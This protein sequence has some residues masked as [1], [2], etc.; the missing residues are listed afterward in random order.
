MSWRYFTRGE[1]PICWGLR[2]DCRQSLETLLVHCRYREANPPDWEEVRPDAWGFMMWRHIST[3]ASYNKSNPGAAW[4]ELQRINKQNKRCKEAHRGEL[5]LTIAILDREIRKVLEQLSLS[6][7]DRERLRSRFAVVTDNVEEQDRLIAESGC[8]SVS[9]WQKLEVAVSDRLPGVKEGGRSLLVRGDGI[10][11]PIANG[12]GKYIGWQ[13]RLD[14]PSNGN[15]Y[16]WLAGERKRA[17]RPTSHLSSGELP[18]ALYAPDSKILIESKNNTIGLAEGIGFKPQI[19][20]NRLGIPFI[21]ASSGNFAGSEKLLKQYLDFLG[22]NKSTRIVLFADAGA[23]NN[24]SVVHVY[25]KTIDLL[26]SWGYRVAIAW[27][28]QISKEDGDIDEIPTEKLETIDYISFKEFLS[29]ANEEIIDRQKPLVRSD[30]LKPE[31]EAKWFKGTID[32][33]I[34]EQQRILKLALQKA[35]LGSENS[36]KCSPKITGSNA[37]KLRETH[38]LSYKIDHR[39]HEPRLPDLTDLIPWKGILNLKSAKDTGKSYQV[40][41]MIETAKQE[42]KKIISITPRIA[43]GREQ[44]V[45]WEINW[46]DDNGYTYWVE[47]EEELTQE[48]HRQK[49]F[50]DE[51]KVTFIS[52]KVKKKVAKKTTNIHEAEALGVCWDSLYKLFQSS[53]YN[54]LVIVDEAEAG[55]KHLLT[56]STL[57]G[58]RSMILS[59]LED[60]IPECLGNG[61]M[62]VLADAD[63]SDLPIDYFKSFYPPTK[64]TTLVNTHKAPKP[65][66]IQ[67]YI[68]QKAKD[69]VYAKLLKLIAKGKKVLIPVD[70][71]KEARALEIKLN[72]LFPNKKILVV[73]RQYTQTKEGKEF[74][75]N[76]NSK[77]KA[78]K[79]DVLIYTPSINMGVSIDVKVFDLVV[80]FYYGVLEP[81]EIRQSLARYRIPV[82]RLIWCN[83]MGLFPDQCR[84]TNAKEIGSNIFKY[85]RDAL[86]QL[87]RYKK[88]RELKRE[89]DDDEILVALQDMRDFKKKEWLDVHI[90]TYCKIM[91]RRNYGLHNLAALLEHQLRQEGHKVKVRKDYVNNGLSVSIGEIKQELTDAQIHQFT[92]AQKISMAEAL[93]RQKRRGS[94]TEEQTIELDKALLQDQLPGV[95]LDNFE[96]N[97]KLL[98]NKRQFLK[99]TRLF[100]LYQNRDACIFYDQKKWSRV[101][102][103]YLDFG[104]IYLPD[105]RA[106]L[107]LVELIDELGLFNLI[108]LEN[109]EQVY[110]KD[111]LD[112]IEFFNRALAHKERIKRTLG[113]TITSDTPPIQLINNLLGKLGIKVKSKRVRVDGVRH[114]IYKLDR[115]RMEDSDRQLLLKAFE[116]KYQTALSELK[117]TGNKQKATVPPQ[118]NN[119][120]TSDGVGQT[121][122]EVSPQNSVPSVPNNIKT[123]D[124]VGQAHVEVKPQKSVPPQPI[125]IETRD[126]IGQPDV[127]VELQKSVPSQSNNIETR[128]GIGQA[129]VEV[130]LQKSVPSQPINIETRDG[131]GQPDVEVQLQNTVPSETINIETKADGTGQAL[132]EVELQKS[133]PP[134][135][136]NIETRDGIGQPDVEVQLQNTVPSVPNNIKTSDGVGQFNVE[137]YSSQDLEY[138]ATHIERICRGETFLLEF[139]SQFS[140]AVLEKVWDV[141]AVVRDPFFVCQCLETLRPSF[142]REARFLLEASF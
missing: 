78:E 50:L 28:G 54:A 115:Q 81:S 6:V 126:G 121:N 30:R 36:E 55:V 33:T 15:K 134:Q 138:L 139:L 75:E 56:S 16:V 39:I 59:G 89:P 35:I 97:K 40:R 90:K 76:I 53:W 79:L 38:R 1:C 5:G 125:N 69:K 132:V 110:T 103:K 92:T 137:G 118:P 106:T 94:L 23:V 105:I 101:K 2:R 25:K 93:E 122:V 20:A 109:S 57:K 87:A 3:R 31:E 61:G 29:F 124:G 108:K 104:L 9:Q 44:A 34:T 19:A 128:D 52:A 65:W 86:E 96:F 85:N 13:V 58:K 47:I 45:R 123:S 27:W 74:V 64:I 77:L 119:I 71:Q 18:I 142:G 135:P 68:S 120:K 100:W 83:P 91:A 63:L 141:L 24:R 8:K 80:G 88:Q 98:L 51:D 21:G 70:S 131:V 112:V 72:Q 49:D 48:S 116:L 22:C 60:K 129:L 46:I 99:A 84:T 42:G 4:K 11:C 62:L 32:S 7:A 43:L 102:D 95:D 12:K 67:L 117:V 41:K 114:Y 14:N 107:P 136:N 73:D 140:T 133:V 82:P 26:E 111:D 130:E 113:L 17:N 37:V 66:H 127:E 10:L